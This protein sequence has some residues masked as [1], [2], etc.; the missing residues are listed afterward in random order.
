[1]GITVKYGNGEIDKNLN[2][3]DSIEYTIAKAS[4]NDNLSKVKSIL[5]KN[6]RID[7]NATVNYSSKRGNGTPLILTGSKKIAKLLIENGAF[8]NKVCYKGNNKITAL[9]SALKELEKAPIQ[10]SKDK[11]K[12]AKKLIKFLKANG[13]K[14]YTDLNLDG[15]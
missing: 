13:A 5:K 10:D 4:Y 9:D 3:N 12:N 8:I 11:I 14:K 2:H 7:L 15:K 1:M 6:K